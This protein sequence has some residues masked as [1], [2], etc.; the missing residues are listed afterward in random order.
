MAFLYRDSTFFN[1]PAARLEA[2]DGSDALGMF[3]KFGGGVAADLLDGAGGVDDAVDQPV[4]DVVGSE[5]VSVRGYIVLKGA[6]EVILG[7]AQGGFFG[8][9]GVGV[10]E[11]LDAAFDGGTEGGEQACDSLVFF[12]GIGD[13]G[14]DEAPLALSLVLFEDWPGCFENFALG[15]DHLDGGFSDQGGFEVVG[16]ERFEFSDGFGRAGEDE[17]VEDFL[18]GEGVHGA[19]NFLEVQPYV[20]L[21]PMLEAHLGEL[22]IFGCC[23][24]LMRIESCLEVVA[25]FDLIHEDSVEAGLG[26]VCEEEAAS[27]ELISGFNEGANVGLESP[28]R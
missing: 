23:V 1:G 24:E 10:D 7:L 14:I 5:A 25:Q 13:E 17:S 27:L 28:K 22:V 3:L 16:E 15:G 18:G 12:G 19:G 21:L 4:V 8:G 20:F 26:A 9:E 2:E 6:P 11:F